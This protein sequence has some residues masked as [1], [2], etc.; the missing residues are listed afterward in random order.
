MSTFVTQAPRFRGDRSISAHLNGVPWHRAPL[1]RRWHPCSP[2]TK[3]KH[4]HY[5]VERCACGAARTNMTR[6]RWAGKNAR[7]KYK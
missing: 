4:F 6:P 2:Q 1:P 5:T 3:A 7:R